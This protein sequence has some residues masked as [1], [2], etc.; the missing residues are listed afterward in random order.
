M[1]PPHGVWLIGARLV[2]GFYSA[3]YEIGAPL[4]CNSRARESN[5]ESPYRIHALTHGHEHHTCNMYYSTHVEELAHVHART[6]AHACTRMYA[7][8][9][10]WAH[11]TA[12]VIVKA[13]R[14]SF[15]VGK[16]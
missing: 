16:E 11:I 2:A 4:N 6:Y 12:R 13:M 5:V 8:T 14:L 15:I 1:L 7:H 3:L 10:G 9:D